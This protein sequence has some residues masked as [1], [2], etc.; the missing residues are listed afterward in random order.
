[1]QA[2]KRERNN[3]KKNSHAAN[4]VATRAAAREWIVE[5]I[6]DISDRLADL[7]AA[8]VLDG[9][10]VMT[11]RLTLDLSQ[12]WSVRDQWVALLATVTN[13]VDVELERN[14]MAW[15]RWLARIREGDP[16]PKETHDNSGLLHEVLARR[17]DEG[18]PDAA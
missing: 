17:D 7:N 8:L 13:L 2:L 11:D 6:L 10:K 5:Q 4:R 9:Q 3:T 1:M 18:T 14:D 16:F 15:G 12:R